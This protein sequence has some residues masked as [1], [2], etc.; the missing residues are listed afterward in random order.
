MIGVDRRGRYAQIGCH[1]S[2]SLPQGS[3]GYNVVTITGI[4]GMGTVR[5]FTSPVLVSVLLIDTGSKRFL[6]SVPKWYKIT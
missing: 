4:V 2:V 3:C 1:A 6:I 5:I